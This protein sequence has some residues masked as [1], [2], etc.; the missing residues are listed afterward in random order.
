MQTKD[1]KMAKKSTV[2]TP[3]KKESIG[4]KLSTWFFKEPVKFAL[5]SFGLI[6]GTSVLYM[7][8]RKLIGVDMNPS[9]LSFGALMLVVLMFSVYKLIKWLPG[10]NLDRRSFVAIDN[11]FSII[12]FSFFLLSTIFI[13]H[14]AQNIMFYTMWLQNYSMA[15]FL[16]AA[17]ILS[18]FY[19]YFI[20]LVVTNIYSTFRRATAMGVPKWKIILS[21][22]FTIMLF[23][24]AGYL[25]PD[26]K[27]EKSVITIK[28]KWYS[29][30]TNWVVGKTS[31]ALLVFL[32]TT[33]LSGLL[34][35]LSSTCFTLF[36]AAIFGVWIWV[37]GVQKFRKSIG[38]AFSSFAA[39]LNIAIIIALIGHLMFMPVTPQPVPQ[40]EMMQATEATVK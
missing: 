4:H 16:I 39:V 11:G 14:N 28:S 23:L 13:A 21:L 7:L 34:F 33:I 10:E 18:L 38:G 29:N 37:M 19:L 2:K 5:L 24:G 25:L 26:D 20:G 1:F 3:I 36:L 15:M 32:I 9:F 6:L 30:F 12:I 17:I 22:P 27:K 35:D 40:Y 8:V 31:H